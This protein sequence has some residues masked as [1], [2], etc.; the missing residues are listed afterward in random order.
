MKKKN[1]VWAVALSSILVVAVMVYLFHDVFKSNYKAYET[2][3]ATEITQQETLMMKSF[4]VRDEQ[5]IDGNSGGTV[6]PL[7][8]DGNRVASGDSVARICKSEED[9]AGYANL[10]KYRQEL[11]RYQRISE[12]TELNSLDMKKLNDDIDNCYT[13]VLEISAGS[14]Y[15]ELSDSVETLENK[16][17]SKQILTDGTIDLTD[18]FNTINQNIASLEKKNIYTSDVVASIS[19]Y[20]ISTVDGYENTVK[21]D[22]VM[23]LTVNDAQKILSSDAVEVSGKM[24]KIVGSYKWYLVSVIDSKY[25]L[26]FKE[27]DTLKINLPY[28]GYENVSV[29]VEKI[30][31]K[32][33][34]KI[35]VVFSCNMMN[36]TYANM[37]IVDAELVL[38]EYTGYKVN[39]SSVRRIT[40][41]K[42]RKIDVVYIIRG[43]IMNARRVEIIYDAGDYLIVKENSESMGGYR[44][45]K[46]YDEVI[47]KGRNLEDGKSI[48]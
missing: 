24:G 20:Y 29:L 38:N 48:S 27:G 47:V 25:S 19:G 22:D 41:E 3:T 17:A 6:V 42:G 37:R 15:S 5:Y 18:K 14:D 9:A 43:N 1:R 45:I 32:S 12:Q 30:S 23:N 26:I 8:K 11:E 13:K 34:G 16:L 39:S 40:D 4:V 46:L 21:Y 2:Q 7:V 35:A 10:L 36:E 44:P 33:D 28:Y 31:E